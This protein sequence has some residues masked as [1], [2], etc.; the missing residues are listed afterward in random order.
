MDDEAKIEK[1]SGC[2]NVLSILIADDHALIRQSLKNTFKQVEGFKVV[3][4]ADN[5]FD[6][7][8]LAQQ[9]KPDVA[10]LDISMPGLNGIEAT[11]IIKKEQPNI[12]AL[13]L[14]VHNDHEHV[15]SMLGAGADG[16]LTKNV[17]AEEI[18]QA[19]RSLISFCS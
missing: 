3:G 1:E 13:V 8:K 16:Y 14:T 11:R 15:L 10:I 9:L 6:A 7:V 5:G 18:V 19:I 2:S 4:E 17:M 12:I